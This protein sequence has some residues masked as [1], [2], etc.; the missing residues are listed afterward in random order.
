MY[1]LIASKVRRDPDEEEVP[2]AKKSKKRAPKL[3]D[4]E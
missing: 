2:T 4:Q 3:I 1:M